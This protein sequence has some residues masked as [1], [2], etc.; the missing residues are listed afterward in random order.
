M[1]LAYFLLFLQFLLCV[2]IQRMGV[3]EGWT[4]VNFGLLDLWALCS[5]FYQAQTSETNEADP[6]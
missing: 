3:W 5:T 2:N 6:S 1:E 4:N